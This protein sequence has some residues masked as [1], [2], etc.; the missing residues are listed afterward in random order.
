MAREKAKGNKPKSAREDR[1]S[2]NASRP[3]ARSVAREQKRKLLARKEEKTTLSGLQ[4]KKIQKT[5]KEI[6]KIKNLISNEGDQDARNK[7]QITLGTLDSDVA[8][9]ETELEDIESNLMEID[10]SIARIDRGEP[11]DMDDDESSGHSDEESADTYNTENEPRG[12]VGRNHQ[13]DDTNNVEQ[14]QQHGD[15]NEVATDNP[16]D[17]T[18]DVE[19]NQQ[20]GNTNDVATDETAQSLHVSSTDELYN[21]GTFASEAHSANE[22]PN[23]VEDQS[24]PNISVNPNELF[25]DQGEPRERSEPIDPEMNRRPADFDDFVLPSPGEDAPPSITLEEGTVILNARSRKLSL[26][27]YGPRNSPM[28]IWSTTKASHKV[29]NVSN[30]LGKP[31][32]EAMN[33]DDDTDA[34]IYKGRIGPIKAIAWLPHKG[35]DTMLGVLRSVEELNPRNKQGSQKYIYP[36]STVLVELEGTAE[37]NEGKNKAVWIDRSKYKALSSSGKSSNER[38]D[39]KFYEMASLQVKKFRDWA[40]KRLD[41]EW[42][43]EAREGRTDRSPTPLRETPEPDSGRLGQD[44]TPPSQNTLSQ[45]NPSHG[46]TEQTQQ[47]LGN[48]QDKEEVDISDFY[49][50]YLEK[51]DVDPDTFWKR[52][53]DSLFAS[54]KAAAA[55]YIRDLTRQN[56]KIVDTKIKFGRALKLN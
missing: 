49:E 55:I 34:L 1:A 33:R 45:E 35:G 21:N 37:Q 28:F 47:A 24:D 11:M 8:Q 20:H 41:E 26:N 44:Q 25:V 15:T 32:K 39:R 16:E 4:A 42:T 9:M 50:A 3:N 56:V 31:H 52:L 23:P 6:Q 2:T 48:N 12:D 22:T 27:S 30:L 14:N 40:G 10:S 38:T 18:N 7:L 13:E 5:K 17:D 36:M 43:G 53:D 29:R 54:F 51:N 19:Q 46:I